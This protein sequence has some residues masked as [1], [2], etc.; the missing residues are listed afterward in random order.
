M[1]AGLILFECRKLHARITR[2]QCERNRMASDHNPRGGREQ[3]IQCPTCRDWELFGSPE[4]P[5]TPANNLLEAPMQP[6][7]KK[8]P[9]GLKAIERIGTCKEC[10]QKKW[11]IAPKEG[12]CMKCMHKKHPERFDFA[13]TKCGAKIK[14]RGLC[15]ACKAAPAAEPV[16]GIP[17][18]LVTPEQTPPPGISLAIEADILEA[19]RQAAHGAYR[20]VEHEMAWR[21][22]ES[23]GLPRPGIQA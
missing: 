16:P 5:G 1:G 18:T 3:P 17:E 19:L 20:T 11:L 9:E 2:E 8:Q 23:L 13:C 7:A 10:G 6:T 4:N 22:R 15:R 14:R 21:L 12:L